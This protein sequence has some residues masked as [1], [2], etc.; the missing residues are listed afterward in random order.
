[1]RFK[2]IILTVEGG[3]DPRNGIGPH[4][5]ARNYDQQPQAFDFLPSTITTRPAM[6]SKDPE[7]MADAPPSESQEDDPITA[8]IVTW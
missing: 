3:T 1:M 2:S 4:H 5:A 7:E 8:R 6:S